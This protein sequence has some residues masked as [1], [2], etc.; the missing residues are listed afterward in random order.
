M[1]SRRVLGEGDEVTLHLRKVYARTLYE[2]P[3]A[4]LDDLR[5]AV[6]TLEE[7][8]R[9]GRRVLGGAHPTVTGIELSLQNARAHLYL[10]ARETPSASA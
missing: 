8:E 2:N 1:Q 6:M 9:T 7:I 5:E 10:R 4:T 3:V